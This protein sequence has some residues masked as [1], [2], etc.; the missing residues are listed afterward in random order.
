VVPRVYNA[1]PDM[2]SL[3]SRFLDTRS[4]A[5]IDRKFTLGPVA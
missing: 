4:F 2:L 5:D 1:A 3:R